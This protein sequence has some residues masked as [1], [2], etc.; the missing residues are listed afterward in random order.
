MQRTDPLVRTKLRLPYTRVELVPRPRLQKEIEEGIRGP[1]TLIT[2]P[3]GFGKTT[4]VA[5]CIASCGM[6]A[7]WLSLDKNDNQSE[8]FLTYL[9]AALQ[10]ADSRIG[11]E[12]AQFMEGIQQPPLEAIL[13][14]LL[15][16]LDS[17]GMETTLVLDDYHLIS[18]PAVHEEVAF[19]LEHCP[20]TFHL[21]IASRSD[22]QLPLSRLRARGQTVELRA[23]D[24]RFTEP[25][26]AQFLNEVMGLHLDAGVV[27]VLEE[28]TEGWIAGL[29]MAA[30]SM[31]DRKDVIGFV[32]GFSGTNRYI[33]DFLLEEILAIQPPE[34]QNF[35]LYTSVLD[36]LTA[37][38]C[39]AL[40]AEA[41][42]SDPRDED[43]GSHLGTSS[44]SQSVSILKYLE[45]EN[46]F[47]V[48][49]DDERT[50]YRY[51]HLFADL[52]KVRLQQAQDDLVSRLHIRSSTWLEKNGYIHEAILH[53]MAAHEDG[54]AADLIMRYAPARLADGDPSVM[55]MADSLP[56]EMILS[57]PIIGLY[58]AWLL[59]IQ[60]RIGEARPLL[61]NLARQLAG[62][63]PDSGQFWMQTI[64]ASAAAFLA[65]PI[66][67]DDLY[68]LPDYQLLEEIPAEEQ[69]LR[70][71]A[72]FLYGMAL[73]RRGELDRAVEV[74]QKCIH[75]ERQ[76]RGPAAIPT[77]APFL[78]R[79]YLML[80]R[81]HESAALCHE[82]LDPM[83]YRDIRF[84]YTSGSMKIDLGE[85]LTEWN[86]LEE[87]EKYINDGLQD[88]QPWQNIMTDGF[89][90]IALAR[91]LRVK[92]DYIGAM[93]IV[94]QFE[95]RMQI[96]SRPR[97][98]D[99]DFYTLRVRLQLASGDLQTP[100]RWADQ[101]QRNGDFDQYK[102]RYCLS[103]ARI[104]LAQGRYNDVENILAGFTPG[105]T[106]GS[107][108]TRQLECNLV[109]AAALAGRRCL[110]E[111]FAIL[112]SCLFLAEP[113]GYIQSFLEIGDPM[114]VLLFAY[115]RA[116]NPGHNKFAKK[117][118]DAFLLIEGEGPP[119][120]KSDELIEP[121]SARELEVL[122][123]IAQGRTNQEIARYLYISP[124]TVKAHTASIYRKLDVA[125]RTEA[126]SRARQLGIF[127]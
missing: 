71:A 126:V 41:G 93:Q 70:N 112:E 107:R 127:T 102:E 84:V 13:A 42:G 27:T 104:R 51:H 53:L 119:C 39:D 31:R 14:S 23:A 99:E 63:G 103:L 69:V 33:L 65:P 2:A 73:A 85:V 115:L 47:L 121:L 81:L 30:L 109:Q 20:K 95:R 38:L 32:E 40:I 5:S 89:G 21:V 49:L 72:D 105:I 86:I 15:N 57:R 77:L 98:F 55:Q 37:P 124:G 76:Q 28:R 59:I 88:N 4:L 11:N 87:A 83:I 36:R 48:S 75:R 125:N 113:E 78:T 92:G 54:R 116:D 22:P 35:L 7:A 3:A 56:H 122:Q 50:W 52:L 66:N 45:R 79:I 97:E 17:A 9:I 61:N 118:L 26:A 90:L 106:S 12:A 29:Q 123:L 100:S 68:P 62:S 110:R 67:N 94:E 120:H 8:R 80:G 10:S 44:M 25:E 82:F 19:L 1:L 108:I 74:A 24:L 114:R 16:D 46:L 18:S 58:Q 91:V 6:P 111:A 117:V 64:I 34:I 60:G 96:G 43:E 101:I